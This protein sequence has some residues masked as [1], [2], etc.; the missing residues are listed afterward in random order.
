[1]VRAAGDTKCV[2]LRTTAAGSSPASPTV[3]F[4]PS[5]HPLQQKQANRQLLTFRNKIQQQFFFLNTAVDNHAPS[6]LANNNKKDLDNNS[7]CC[8][9]TPGWMD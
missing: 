3:E 2:V 6:R 8:G 7:S 9:Q 5:V 1:M 4:Q